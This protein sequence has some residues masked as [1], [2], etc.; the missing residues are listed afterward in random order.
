MYEYQLEGD[1][2]GSQG[3]PTNWSRLSAVNSCGANIDWTINLC[4]DL[5]TDERSM[6]GCSITGIHVGFHLVREQPFLYT[7]SESRTHPCTHTHTH[8]HTCNSLIFARFQH[9]AIGSDTVLLGSCGLYFEQNSL[10]AGVT[11]HQVGRNDII[12]WP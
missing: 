11:Q 7:C 6:D 10:W 9:T 2:R 12:E 8:T 4:F 3:P 1:M 5:S